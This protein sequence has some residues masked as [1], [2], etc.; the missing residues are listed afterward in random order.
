MNEGPLKLE[1]IEGGKSY[2][3]EST[4]EEAIAHLEECLMRI[5]LPEGMK[6]DLDDLYKREHFLASLDNSEFDNHDRHMARIAEEEISDIRKNLPSHLLVEY[7]K[8]FAPKRIHPVK[9]DYS[10]NQIQG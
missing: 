2:D 7:G 8:D 3:R 5:E 1:V 4:R 6:S 10:L 9:I